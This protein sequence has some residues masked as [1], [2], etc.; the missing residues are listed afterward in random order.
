M[1]QLTGWQSTQKSLFVEAKGFS[2]SQE[3][4]PLYE[5]KRFITVFTRLYPKPDKAN[6]WYAILFF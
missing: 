3:I 4:P 2:A 6:P 1:Y 5:T